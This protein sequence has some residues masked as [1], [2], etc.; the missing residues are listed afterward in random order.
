MHRFT[1][2]WLQGSSMVPDAGRHEFVDSLCPGL[3][4]RVSA[5]G[6][7]TFSA[8]V[9][10]RGALRRETIGKYPRVTLSEA[11]D[12]ALASLRDADN[13]A[14]GHP[15]PPAATTTLQELI[16][17]YVERHLKPNARSWKNIRASLLGSKRYPS[18][19]AH[20][21]ARPVG[22]IR[23]IEIV[24]LIDR[25]MA[26]GKPQAAVNLLR[27][28]KMLFNWGGRSRRGPGQPLRAHPASRPYPRA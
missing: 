26:E 3:H 24:D 25:V 2:K 17:A 4:L 1:D 11:R 8:L 10:V 13:T 22:E 15:R 9:R 27:H 16:D 28:I 20:L 7:K 12:A 23:K 21:L 5:K 14:S 18:R 6:T 19:L